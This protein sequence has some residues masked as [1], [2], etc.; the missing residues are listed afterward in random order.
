MRFLPHVVDDIQRDRGAL[1]RSH[2]ED[3][4]HDFLLAKVEDVRGLFFP[5]SDFLGP[6]ISERLT[7]AHRGTHWPLADRG[8]VVARVTLHHLLLGLHHLGNSKGT[9]DHTVAARNAAWF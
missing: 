9:S 8:T 5:T 1:C 2:H 4:S 7:R 3:L 6:D